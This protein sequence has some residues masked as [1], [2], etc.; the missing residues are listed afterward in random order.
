MKVSLQ[1][2]KMKIGGRLRREVR[3]DSPAKMREHVSRSLFCDGRVTKY[4]SRY[5]TPEQRMYVKTVIL[6]ER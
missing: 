6:G 1:R 4:I 3:V 2:L 5:F